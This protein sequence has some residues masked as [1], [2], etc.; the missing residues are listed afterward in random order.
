MTE[1]HTEDDW[2]SKT[3]RKKN[4]DNVL[5]LGEQLITLSK[6]DLAL[7][8][9]ED[10]LRHAVEEALRIKSHGALKRQK[11]YIAKLMRSMDTEELASQVQRTLHKHDIHNATFKRMEK[12]RDAMLEDGDQSI[13]AFIKQYPHA[14]RSHLRQLVRNAKKEKQTDKPPVTYRQIFKYIREIVDQADNPAKNT[15]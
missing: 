11:H 9:M 7:I 6:E 10:S 3:Q 2:V 5:H 1:S 13:N 14:E 4:C 12:W 15:P 8:Q